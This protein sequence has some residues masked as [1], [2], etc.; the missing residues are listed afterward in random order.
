M[1]ENREREERRPGPGGPGRGPRGMMEHAK[2][3][4][5]KGTFKRLL[6]YISEHIGRI[7]L[8]S[9]L[10]AVSALISILITRLAG[11]A[12]DDYI[13]VG[14]MPGLARLVGVSLLLYAVPTS[15]TP[16]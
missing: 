13:A 9:I 3:K 1:S 16:T 6:K 8:I 14:D 5:A 4:D 11:I 12:V 7:V 15:R 10:C 2:A